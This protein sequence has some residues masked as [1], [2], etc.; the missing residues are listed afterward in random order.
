MMIRP[1]EKAEADIKEIGMRAWQEPRQCMQ[2]RLQRKASKKLSFQWYKI[3]MSEF[4]TV[5]SKKRQSAKD[6]PMRGPN[7]TH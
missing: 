6:G 1:D 4:Q 7:R 2:A 3:Y 5:V